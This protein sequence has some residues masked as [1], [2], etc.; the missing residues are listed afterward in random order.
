MLSNGMRQFSKTIAAVSEA[1]MPS[2]SSTRTTV[3]PGVP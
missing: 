2:L 3:A 1:R